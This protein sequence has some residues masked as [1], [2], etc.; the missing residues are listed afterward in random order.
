MKLSE[1]DRDKLALHTAFAVHQIARYLGGRSD[2]P[3]EIRDR[4]R[5]H[6][7]AIEGVLVTSGHDW[8]K[9]EMEATEASLSG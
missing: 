1:D 9:D 7:S 3:P 5:G 6:I 4:L 8:I 2:V